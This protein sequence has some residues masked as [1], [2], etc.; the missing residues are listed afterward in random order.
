VN[1]TAPEVLESYFKHL[2]SEGLTEE[3]LLQKEVNNGCINK[4]V[5]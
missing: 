2:A 4:C 3:E 5:S 1:K